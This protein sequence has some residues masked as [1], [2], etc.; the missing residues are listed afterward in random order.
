MDP[1]ALVT[2]SPWCVDLNLTAMTGENAP[3]PSAEVIPPPD[4]DGIIEGRDGRRYRLK[5]AAALAARI[6]AQQVKARIDFDH[7]SERISPTFAGSTAAEGWLKNARPNARGGIDAD[8]ELSSW[9]A[10]SLRSGSYR[11]LSPA[12]FHTSDMEV[13]GLSSVGLVNDPNFNLPAPTMHSTEPNVDNDK[14]TAEREKALEA[15]E[16]AADARALNA[17]VRAVDQA[18]ADGKI[19][20]AAKDAHLETIKS[21]K[22]GIDAGLNAFEKVIAASAGAAP[23][24]GGLSSQALETLGT[25]V[26]PAGA[27]NATGA[28]SQPAFPAPAG[29]LPPDAD[30]LSLHAKIADYAQK[31]GVSYRDAVTH[32]GAMGT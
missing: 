7:R 9:A 29:V 14:D 32:F 10:M 22:D 25:R 30:R 1:E 12:L 21:H 20:A 26:G 24:A 5:D 28:A 11:Y 8:L 19:P 3:P 15:R 6:N 4:G 16:K 2:L 18:V 31:N 23:G 27:P 17:A 13:T